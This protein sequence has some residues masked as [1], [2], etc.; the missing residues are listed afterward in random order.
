MTG[1]ALRFP[2]E[3]LATFTCSFGSSDIAEYELVGTKGHLRLE[4]AYEY[5]GELK[6]VTTLDGKKSEKI[7]P[8]GDQFGAGA[9]LFFRL[10]H[11][12]PLPDLHY[13]QPNET[14]RQRRACAIHFMTPRHERRRRERHFGQLPS[15]DAPR[16]AIGTRRRAAL[17]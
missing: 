7:F 13:T 8:P 3:R 9:D 1:A 12:S 5:R 2:G 15:P 17:T 4:N 14:D 10:Y 11:V 6:C 16:P